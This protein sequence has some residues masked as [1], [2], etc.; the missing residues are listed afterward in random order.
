MIAQMILI[1]W[2]SIAIGV[3]IA[4]HGEPETGCHSFWH[5]FGG[6]IILLVI[7]YFGGFFDCWK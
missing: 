1:V 5:T 2:L 7:L 3:G 4:K 6:I